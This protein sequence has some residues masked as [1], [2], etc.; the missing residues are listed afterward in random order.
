MRL[1]AGATAQA[2]DDFRHAVET[3]PRDIE[4][5]D[6]LA[7]AAARAGRLDEAEQV[8]R[9]VAAAFRSAP[10]LVELSKVLAARGR[11]DEAT[12]TARDAVLLDPANGAAFEQLA[13]MY[14]DR[15]DVDALAQLVRVVD[16]LP[17]HRA[18]GLYAR[19][20]IAHLQGDLEHAASA[21]E[22]L[23][24]VSRSANALNLLGSIRAARGEYDAAKRALDD[25][26]ALVPGDA[27]VRTNL[28]VL[29]LR[30]ANPAAAAE[31]FS[32]ALFL[33]PT[34]A[35]ALDGLAQA[36]E[37]LGQRRRAEAIRRLIR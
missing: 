37:R 12:D 9:H 26:L 10:A 19:A 33:Q 30:S 34:L 13:W 24:A 28:G 36:L 14:A 25:S 29:E 15:R 21:G 2:F 32:E 8:L 31:R 11:S 7:R 1:R 6:G 16:G 18:V 20:S 35:T 4:A 17:A 3:D 23:V 22:Q 5:L 27:V